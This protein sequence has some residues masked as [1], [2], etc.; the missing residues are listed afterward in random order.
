MPEAAAATEEECMAWQDPLSLNPMW[1]WSQSPSQ[2]LQQSAASSRV[3]ACRSERAERG[4]WGTEG[5][6]EGGEAG[7]G[8]RMAVGMRM[9][10]G[11]PMGGT[12][13]VVGML[14]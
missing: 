12:R 9:M 14:G 13:R 10:D 2:S 11:L 1:L 3:P 8:D 5:R 7:K 6:R 4:K